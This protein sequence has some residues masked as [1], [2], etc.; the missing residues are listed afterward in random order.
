VRAENRK[1]GIR[2]SQQKRAKRRI[3]CNPTTTHTVIVVIVKGQPLSPNGDPTCTQPKYLCDPC[4]VWR[5]HP[6][7]W[8]W[9]QDLGLRFAHH[10]DHHSLSYVRP[11][12]SS[13]L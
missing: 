10:S 3:E 8:C 7:L 9:S 1:Y 11:D 13:G 5:A 4:F 12:A 6:R 2:D